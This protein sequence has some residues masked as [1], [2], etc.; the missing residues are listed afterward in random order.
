MGG[1]NYFLW[2]LIA[3]LAVAG[4]WFLARRRAEEG[5]AASEEDERSPV[6]VEG[7]NAYTGTRKG[8]KYWVYLEGGSARVEI[9]T[10]RVKGP[11]FVSESGPGR[12]VLPGDARDGD[13]RDLIRLGA[14]RVEA[15]TEADL[16]SAHFEARALDLNSGTRFGFRPDAHVLGR[17]VELLIAVRDKGLG[18]A[19]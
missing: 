17:V 6:P 9:E 8:V 1:D 4:A 16:L 7:S 18:L 10:G 14:V 13:V 15:A 5:P 2:A 11:P 12:A 19:R 3:A